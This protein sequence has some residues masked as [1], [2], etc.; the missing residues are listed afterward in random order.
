MRLPLKNDRKEN[1]VMINIL[2]ELLTVPSFFT[3]A[4]DINL[5]ITLLRLFSSMKTYLDTGFKTMK[6]L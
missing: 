2:K 3:Q 4:L 5:V 6:N 1:R